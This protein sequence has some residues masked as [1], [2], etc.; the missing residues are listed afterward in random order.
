MSYYTWDIWS[1][2][3]IIIVTVMIIFHKMIDTDKIGPENIKFIKFINLS[4]GIILFLNIII[5]GIQNIIL[6]HFSVDG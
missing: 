4:I 3:F 5:I 6:Q 2:V 1:S